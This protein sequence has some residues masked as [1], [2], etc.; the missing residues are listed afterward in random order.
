MV[1]PSRSSVET[2]H[3]PSS[4]SVPADKVPPEGMSEIVR[5]R[6]SESSVTAALIF[7]A[8]EVSS[9]PEISATAR[10]GASA[11]AA[12]DTLIVPILLVVS[13]PSASVE[14]AVTVRVKSASELAAGVM[15][16]S[17]SWSGSS[18]QDP[19]PLS[20]PVDSAAPSGTP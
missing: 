17:S 10:L 3:E 6:V 5:D 15:V 4:L 16:K 12:T 2:V 9:L 8:M 14:V 19:S 13:P 7:R 11:S 1:R 20:V 18:V